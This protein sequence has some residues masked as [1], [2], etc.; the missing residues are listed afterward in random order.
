MNCTLII[1]NPSNVLLVVFACFALCFG[2][3]DY[4][5]TLRQLYQM[6]SVAQTPDDIERIK[7]QIQQ[8][9]Q[10]LENPTHWPVPFAQEGNRK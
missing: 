2:F 10:Q 5:Q 9:L 8:V 7:F 3:R 4:A 1:I 6:M